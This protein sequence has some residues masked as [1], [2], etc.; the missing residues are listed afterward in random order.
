LPVTLGDVARI[1]IGP[2]IRRGIAE[3][4]GE[5]DVAGGVVLMR[6]AR[7]RAR[8]SPRSG[9]ARELRQALPPGVEVVTTYDRSRSIDRASTPAHKLSR[10]SSS[11]RSCCAVPRGTCAR[12][13]S[14]SSRAARR[15]AAFVVMR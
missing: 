12:R 9:E 10:S 4:D 5:G 3:L 13:S 15:A 1:Q 6:S 2:E 11:S 7:T 14:R 8:P